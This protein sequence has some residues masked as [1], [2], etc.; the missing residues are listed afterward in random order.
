MVSVL[1]MWLKIFIAASGTSPFEIRGDT[2]NA[3]E[4]PAARAADLKTRLG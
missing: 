3:H 1:V 2:V 4:R